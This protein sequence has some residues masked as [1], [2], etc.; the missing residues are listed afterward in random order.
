MYQ[1]ASRAK[2]NAVGR[3]LERRVRRSPNDE[4]TAQEEV[5]RCSKLSQDAHPEGR[6]PGKREQRAWER[7][8]MPER[9]AGGQEA[10]A[11][12]AV[13][14]RWRWP[15]GARPSHGEWR[16]GAKLEHGANA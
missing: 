10:Q 1:G 5:G 12:F 3:R 6:W 16:L 13:P 2:R 11:M 14:A 7:T 9:Y 15:T 4:G 8:P